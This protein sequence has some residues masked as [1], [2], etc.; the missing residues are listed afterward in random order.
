MYPRRPTSF[1]TAARGTEPSA[2]SGRSCSWMSMSRPRRRSSFTATPPW[3]TVETTWPRSSMLGPRCTLSTAMSH[4][5][6]RNVAATI[7]KW[8]FD[9]SPSPGLPSSHDT[10]YPSS[11][12]ISAYRHSR[13]RPWAARQRIHA[14]RSALYGCCA[15]YSLIRC[16]ATSRTKDVTRSNKST[17]CAVPNTHRLSSR[18][19]SCHTKHCNHH[20]ERAAASSRYAFDKSSAHSVTRRSA[21]SPPAMPIPAVSERMIATASANSASLGSATLLR[22]PDWMPSLRDGVPAGAIVSSVVTRHFCFRRSSPFSSCTHLSC[23]TTFLGGSR[24]GTVRRCIR[25]SVG[26]VRHE[27]SARASPSGWNPMSPL[28]ALLK[29]AT[30]CARRGRSASSA[31]GQP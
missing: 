10:P 26:F 30:L 28:G 11:R 7:A 14:W 16:F 9:R 6:A 19:P 20:S 29:H 3:P 12:Y 21:V 15:S 8:A 31:L 17:R 4:P 22:S 13:P 25:P 5:A 1:S 27:A 2:R 24:A 18:T 23:S